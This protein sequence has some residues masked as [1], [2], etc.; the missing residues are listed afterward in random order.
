MTLEI[1]KPAK[2]LVATR[3]ITLA[4]RVGQYH[5]LNIGISVEDN[6][7]CPGTELLGRAHDPAEHTWT[8]DTVTRGWWLCESCG[9]VANPETGEC[10]LAAED[11][12]P[13]GTETGARAEAV[14]VFDVP[15]SRRPRTR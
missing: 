3:L 14:P 10:F 6:Y 13:P 5:P 8:P 12:P 7:A 15:Q 2:R 1:N 4:D 11:E 9:I